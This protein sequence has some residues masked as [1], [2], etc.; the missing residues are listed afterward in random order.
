MKKISKR[1]LSGFF[2]IVIGS[3]FIISSCLKAVSS[4]AFVTLIGQYGIIFPQII[5]PLIIISEFLIGTALILGIEQRFV[6]SCSIVLLIIFSVAYTYGLLCLDISD[7]G[8]FGNLHILNVSPMWLYVRNA[9]L[10][11]MSIFIFLHPIKYVYSF[12]NIAVTLGILVIGGSIVGYL[13]GQSAGKFLNGRK[14][15]NYTPS[16]VADSPLNGLISVNP[17]STYLIFAF[18]YSCPHCLN[19]IANLNQYEKLKVVDKVIGIAKKKDD[20]K[21]FEHW[22]EPEFR[23]KEIEPSEKMITKDFPTSF[24]IRNDSVIKVIKGELPCALIF[25]DEIENL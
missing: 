21:L 25:A 14:N 20:N 15:A 4:A 7:C 17:D 8:C 9:L 5:S 22:F 13:A 2:G 19:S 6:S 24:Y 3:I 12:K 18:S 11:A 1:N 16:L 10:L 23:I